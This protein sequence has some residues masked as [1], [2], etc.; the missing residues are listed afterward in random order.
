[1]DNSTA[2]CLNI[3]DLPT[4]ILLMIFNKLNSIEI[5]HSVTHV[6]RRFYQLSLDSSC[7]RDLQ[8]TSMIDVDTCYKRISPTDIK[9]ISRICKSILP[10][11]N[12]HVQKLT[13]DQTSLIP[14]L[15]AINYPQLH[16]LTIIDIQE[17]YLL[18]SLKSKVLLLISHH[19]QKSIL[20]RQTFISL[21]LKMMLFFA[22]FSVI[23]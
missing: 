5:F 3:L 7:V 18:H 16:S 8:I 15:H 20:I 2:T 9:L 22:I 23:K 6:N 21:F 12:H 17:E 19:Q 1:M 4:E 13:V 11:I 10:K 14:T